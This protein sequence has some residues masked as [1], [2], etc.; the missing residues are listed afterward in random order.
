MPAGSP[1]THEQAGI[2]GDVAFAVV[3]VGTERAGRAGEGVALAADGVAAVV[4]GGEFDRAGLHRLLGRRFGRWLGRC[5]RLWSGCR[6]RFR[7][8]RGL[9]LGSRRL[10]LRLARVLH[11][12]LDRLPCGDGDLLLRRQLAVAAGAGLDQ[13]VVAGRQ[14]G[15]VE[16]AVVALVADVGQARFVA[17]QGEAGA[18]DALALLV[19]D[20]D[21]E[22]ARSG[23][24]GER[25]VGGL[26]GLD[27]DLLR[28]GRGDAARELAQRHA[29][30]TNRHIVDANAA[31]AVTGV[32][33][34]VVADAGR[35]GIA[36]QVDAGGQRLPRRVRYTHVDSAGFRLGLLLGAAAEDDLG[37]L[38]TGDIELLASGVGG[39]R[40]GGRGRFGDGD[41][42][43]RDALDGD[44]A[45]TIFVTEGTEGLAPRRDLDGVAGA[46]QP[47]AGGVLGNDGGARPA[48]FRPRRR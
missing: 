42:A 7:D 3:A 32:A 35:E 5:V 26:A 12:E 4:E 18:A 30:G 33:L 37:P 41:R 36:C 48:P 13:G 25:D 29:V 11:G 24:Y 31:G 45:V 15:D 17:A 14:V 38:A 21:D 44:A 23:R 40:V 9:R 6:F 46:G 16:T 28:F 19:L 2:A 22:R 43:R 1:S 47:V 10:R 20:E 27:V 8:G 39:G 34:A